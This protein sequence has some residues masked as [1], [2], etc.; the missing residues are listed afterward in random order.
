MSYVF[1]PSSIFLPAWNRE[2]QQPFCKH[3]V[4]NHMVW[5]EQQEVRRRLVLWW[6]VWATTPILARLL[7]PFMMPERN[8]LFSGETIVTD[9]LLLAAK[10]ILVETANFK[11]WIVLIYN[12][13]KSTRFL[14]LVL[15]M[16]CMFYQMQIWLWGK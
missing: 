16:V 5:M 15:F 7:L 9:Y 3:E 1:C 4:E 14:L 8:K 11:N 2:G 13:L 10:H 6:L 12:I